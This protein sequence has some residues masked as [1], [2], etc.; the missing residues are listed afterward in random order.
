MPSNISINSQV[1][2]KFL[3]RDTVLYDIYYCVGYSNYSD[4]YVYNSFKYSDFIKDTG[5]S[6]SEKVWWY[7]APNDI[8]YIRLFSKI[9][10]TASVVYIFFKFKEGPFI[11]D[12]LQKKVNE[13]YLGVVL[14]Y[15]ASSKDIYIIQDDYNYVTLDLRDYNVNFRVRYPESYMIQ[16]EVAETHYHFN[17]ADYLNYGGFVLASPLNMLQTFEAIEPKPIGLL[18]RKNLF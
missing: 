12:P 13:E 14:N 6:L 17:N 7:L 15:R 2:E 18:C 1:L 8:L 16:N 4:D 10:E 5:R 11:E 9:T 3:Q